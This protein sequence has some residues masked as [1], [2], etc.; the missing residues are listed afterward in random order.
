MIGELVLLLK[1]GLEGVWIGEEGFEFVGKDA[2][3]VLGLEVKLPVDEIEDFGWDVGVGV[4]SF[5]DL[6]AEIGFDFG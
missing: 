3:R 1:G 6:V 2:E 5:E 4:L